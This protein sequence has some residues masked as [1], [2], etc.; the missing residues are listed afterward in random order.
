MVIWYISGRS[1]GLTDNVGPIAVV[2][3]TAI[4]PTTHV[5]KKRQRDRAAFAGLPCA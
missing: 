4:G 2:T 3:A 1:A 5:P